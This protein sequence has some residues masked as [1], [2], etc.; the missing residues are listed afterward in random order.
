[1]IHCVPNV[2]ETKKNS[3]VTGGGGGEAEIESGHTFL[4]FFNPFFR[5]S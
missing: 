2:I 5:V 3:L 1:M 4:R